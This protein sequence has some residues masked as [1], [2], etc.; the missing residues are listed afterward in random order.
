[1]S[2]EKMAALAMSFPSGEVIQGAAPWDQLKVLRWL[3]EFGGSHGERCAAQFLLSVWNPSTDWVDMAREHGYENPEGAGRFDMQEAL[4]VWDRHHRA[5][6][7][8]W[9]QEPWWP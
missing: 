6:F 7:V 3:C 8:A 9:V 4:G 2:A 1:M 5:A